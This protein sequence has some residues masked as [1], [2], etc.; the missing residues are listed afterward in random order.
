MNEVWNKSMLGLTIEIAQLQLGIK[1]KVKQ[2]F[3]QPK[4]TI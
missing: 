4:Y 3:F 1:K 2:V